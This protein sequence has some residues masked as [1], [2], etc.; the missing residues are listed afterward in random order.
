[1]R[2]QRHVARRLDGAVVALQRPRRVVR[3]QQVRADRGRA[4]AARAP[5]ARGI[6]RKRVR[7]I[8]TG[9]TA[10]RR[11]RPAPGQVLAELA[12]DGGGQRRERQRRARREVGAADEQV[13]AVQRHHDRPEPR[14][15]RRPRRQPEVRVHDVEPLPAVAPAQRRAPRARAPAARARTRT[16]RPRGRRAAGSASTWSRTNGPSHGRSRDGYMFV[17]TRTRTV[18]PP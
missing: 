9:R 11:L 10:T 3:E 2:Q 1:M 4:R 6:G 13:V 14:E 5:R 12:R 8:P 7:S 15:Q 16:A 17:T 18:G